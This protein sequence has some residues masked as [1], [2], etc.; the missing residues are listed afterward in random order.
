M[1]I[2]IKAADA[3]DRVFR[4][5]LIFFM[6]EITF[7]ISLAVISRYFLNSPIYWAEEVT[8]YAFVWATFLGAGCAYRQKEL[9]A[10]S[11][12]LNALSPMARNLVQLIL[13]IIIGCF[14]VL[15][16]IFGIKMTKVVAPQLAVSTRISLAWLYCVV[17]ISCAFM[18]MTCIE[19][20]RDLIL[21]PKGGD[22]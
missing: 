21:G 1:H 3:V 5:L 13:E 9:V 18:L 20:I 4:Y 11:V 22:L 19:N 14:L 7:V 10:M 17:P 6:V 16:V 15:A 2:F 8:R 12:V